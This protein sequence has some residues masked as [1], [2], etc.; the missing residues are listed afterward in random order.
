M[1]SMHQSALFTKH[2]GL[3]R[4][5]KEELKRPSPDAAKIQTLKKMKLQ[6]KEELAHL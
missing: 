5:L 3:E 4:K 2:E 1:G 6:I